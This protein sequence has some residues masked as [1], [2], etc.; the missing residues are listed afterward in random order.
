MASMFT[1]EF[2][3]HLYK[4]EEQSNEHH[5]WATL[6]DDDDPDLLWCQN[7][8][9]TE[10]PKMERASFEKQLRQCYASGKYAISDVA[11]ACHT[12]AV[13]IIEKLKKYEL[14]QLN[15][16]LHN[17]WNGIILE[18]A[19]SHKTYFVRDKYVAAK[20]LNSKTAS[21]N[22]AIATKNVLFGHY[23][24]RVPEYVSRFPEFRLDEERLA[25]EEVIEVA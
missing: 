1:N 9:N 22:G 17:F 18:H 25:N 12:S 8:I 5:S 14:T 3:E 7:Y 10:L 13:N 19:E 11:E 2:Y 4:L 20:M 15:D 6:V 16:A 24:C 23:L 21:V